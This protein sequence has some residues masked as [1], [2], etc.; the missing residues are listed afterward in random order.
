MAAVQVGGNGGRGATLTEAG[1]RSRLLKIGKFI[2]ARSGFEPFHTTVVK[3]VRQIDRSSYLLQLA[4]IHRFV[5]ANVS[6]V[7]DSCYRDAVYPPEQT[8]VLGGGDCD[9]MAASCGVLA[10]TIGFPIKLRAVSLSGDGYDHVYVLALV[11]DRGAPAAWFAMDPVFYD[12]VG[13]SPPTKL[14]P[15]EVLP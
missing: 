14:P 7:R 8:L 1:V 4:A 15:I 13:V 11:S 9:D 5:R 6:Y 2:R 12:V 3:L 10:S